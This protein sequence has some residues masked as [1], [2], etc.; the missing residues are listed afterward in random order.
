MGYE[1]TIVSAKTICVVDLNAQACHLAMRV[2]FDPRAWYLATI[3]LLTVSPD[4]SKGEY[5]SLPGVAHRKQQLYVLRWL[6][7]WLATSR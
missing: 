5:S 7:F 3:P 2:V 4:S 1:R 6:R